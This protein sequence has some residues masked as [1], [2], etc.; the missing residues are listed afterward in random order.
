MYCSHTAQYQEIDPCL[1]LSA[2]KWTW[3]RHDQQI[4]DVTNDATAVSY[5][6]L[7]CNQIFRDSSARAVRVE[8]SRR[9]SEIAEMT[10]E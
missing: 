6:W 4:G 3:L 2:G 5:V 10:C 8:W 7:S 1:V 9:L